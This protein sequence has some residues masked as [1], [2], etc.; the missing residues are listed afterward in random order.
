MATWT[1]VVMGA[2]QD[3]A[4]R[5][6]QLFDGQYVQAGQKGLKREG[7]CVSQWEFQGKRLP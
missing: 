7:C 4:G 6:G 5:E 3:G 1:S 2:V